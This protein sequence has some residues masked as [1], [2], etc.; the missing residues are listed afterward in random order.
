MPT[1]RAFIAAGLALLVPLPAGA[2]FRN[3]R[4]SPA[5]EVFVDPFCGCCGGWI[6]HM[7]KA[8]FTVARTVSSEMRA[9]KTRHGVP[10][11]L[12]SCHTALVEGYVIE[13]HVPARDVLALLE[14]RPP[15]RGL[16]APGMPGGSP[17]MEVPGAPPEPFQVIGFAADGLRAVFSDYPRGY[18][19]PA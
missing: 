14:R 18:A 11:D 2:W 15:L 7:R 19:G 3:A 6:T 9:V 12:A 16:A 13:G 4:R 5:I 8:G 1:R 10:D 17:G